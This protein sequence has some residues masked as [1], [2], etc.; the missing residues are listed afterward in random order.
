M[1]KYYL[2]PLIVAVI[3]TA[4]ILA[5]LTG[6][7]RNGNPRRRSPLNSA[8]SLQDSAGPQLFRAVGFAEAPVVR[9]ISA[10][11]ARR[12]AGKREVQS[13]D[14]EEAMERQRDKSKKAAQEKD[15]VEQIITN[16]VDNATQEE[17][18]KNPTNR[19]IT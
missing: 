14:R 9:D 1:K 8:V 19:E 15:L 18:E 5:P 3:L 2:F 11:Q 6:A 10:A 17:N 13:I 7:S 4:L 16:G 12:S